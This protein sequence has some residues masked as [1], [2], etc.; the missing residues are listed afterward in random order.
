MNVYVIIGK[1]RTL[2]A[3]IAK[4]SRT[5]LRP[6]TGGATRPFQFPVTAHQM[7][8]ATSTK[9]RYAALTPHS[10]ANRARRPRAPRRN[11][12]LAAP[13]D[14]A[15]KP[16]RCALSAQ[17]RPAT[18]GAT[19]PFQSPLTKW[20][21]L[22]APKCGMPYAALTFSETLLLASSSLLIIGHDGSG[23]PI[24][25]SEV[26]LFCTMTQNTRQH[27]VWAITHL[28][29]GVA[30]GAPQTW[31][32][33]RRRPQAAPANPPSPCL[34]RRLEARPGR[35]PS[36]GTP[37]FQIR[38]APAQKKSSSYLSK[39]THLTVPNH[40]YKWNGA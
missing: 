2:T 26:V 4:G 10:H 14:D 30:D 16:P 33:Q 21:A 38:D 6:A 35:L 13:L 18:G 37:R 36:F 34:C 31:E 27:W 39:G 7:D 8:C 25:R 24:Y 20:M 29:R 1:L 17:L 28:L 22:P 40:A 12:P 32:R 9:V 11:R 19:R 5:Q 15:V 3:K 23:R